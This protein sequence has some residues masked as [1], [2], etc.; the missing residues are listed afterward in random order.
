MRKGKT[1]THPKY[2]REYRGDYTYETLNDGTR[3]RGFKLIAKTGK[4]HI[5]NGGSPRHAKAIG[6]TCK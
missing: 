2:K 5:L 6:W 1:W 3:F 4:K